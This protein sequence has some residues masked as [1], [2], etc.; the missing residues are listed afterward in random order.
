MFEKCICIRSFLSRLKKIRSSNTD[1]TGRDAWIESGFRKN[2]VKW[3]W[4]CCWLTCRPHAQH[5]AEQ[6]LQAL[7]T[8]VRVRLSCT[9]SWGRAWQTA[10]AYSC[11][12]FSFHPVLTPGRWF[13]TGSLL[14]NPE[15]LK[16][17]WHCCLF[18]LNLMFSYIST[19]YRSFKMT[20][21]ISTSSVVTKTSWSYAL[22]F[23]PCS[24]LKQTKC[25]QLQV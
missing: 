22:L 7:C 8:C 19:L 6:V 21:I 24:C 15:H 14:S 18:G 12:S 13:L 11:P 16:S 20:S 1:G 3:K 17:P 9:F 2:E 4:R 5:V 25:S 10:Q 23:F